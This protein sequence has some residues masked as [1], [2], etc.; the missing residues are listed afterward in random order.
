[1]NNDISQS[2]GE[3][4]EPP[5]PEGKPFTWAEVLSSVW[6][7]KKFI[8]IF[9]AAATVIAIGITFLLTPLYTA[10]TSVLPELAREK[11]LG[12]AGLA[13]LAEAAGVSV[14]ETPVSKLYPMIVKSERILRGVI[15]HKYKTPQFA[16]S[17]TLA[18]YWEVDARNE[19][20]EFDRAVRKLRSRMDVSFDM[21]LGTVTIGVEMEEPQLAADVANQITAELDEYTRTKRRTNAT[22]QR[23]FVEKRLQE[24]EEQLR[25]SEVALKEFRERNR[26]VMDSPQLML[27]QERLARD[28][29]INSTVFIELKKQ[30]E[31]VKI[32]EIKNIPIIN[33]LDP[34]R[35][36]VRRS[37]PVRRQ[38]ALTTFFLSLFAA[39]GFAAFKD[40]G[41]EA[42]KKVS[43]VLK[44]H[45]HGS[46][47]SGEMP[48]EHG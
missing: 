24:V 25:R 17:V 14:G 31:V 1:M 34:A 18:E 45:R 5:T 44:N 4:T 43:L 47:T 40:K 27:E 32:E 42:L 13:S 7:Y 46:T 16:D 29:E 38:A 23:E 41:A 35:P 30:N 26:Q 37:S 22:L 39:V 6:H 3:F 8:A 19:N 9:V 12:L 28:V 20:E 21:R 10:E 15:Y 11:T 2:K 33:I 48:S 36:P